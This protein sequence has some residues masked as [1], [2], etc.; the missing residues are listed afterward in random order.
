ML[1]TSAG[2]LALLL[3]IDGVLH[4]GD[5][6]FPGAIEALDDLRAR[7]SGVRMVT[8][9]TSQPRMGARSEHA[10]RGF[11]PVGSMLYGWIPSF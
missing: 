10:I 8:N 7:C 4:V 1:A 11:A 9:T 3:D 6:P 2:S 5:E